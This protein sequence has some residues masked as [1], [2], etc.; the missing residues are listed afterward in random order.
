MANHDPLCKRTES[1]K[2]NILN[3]K[4]CVSKDLQYMLQEL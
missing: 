3:V 4:W 2:G 1:D